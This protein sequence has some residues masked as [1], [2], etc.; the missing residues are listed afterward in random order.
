MPC[1]LQLPHT[2]IPPLLSQ[3]RSKRDADIAHR[4]EISSKKKSSTLKQAQESV[5]EFYENYNNKKDKSIA[6][7]RQE[8]D[9]FLENR[10]DTT[11]GGTSWQRIARLVDL[12]ASGSGG[13]KKGGKGGEGAGG[14][15]LGGGAG[16]GADK[17]RFRSLLREL[18]KDEKAPGASGY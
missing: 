3:W 9:E 13:G 12:N 16:S 15:E 1:T 11:S 17:E 14:G 7:T 6:Q 4:A 10:Q 2:D 8:A 5:D 18:A